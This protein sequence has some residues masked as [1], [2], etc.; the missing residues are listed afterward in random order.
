MDMT[1]RLISLFQTTA[2]RAEWVGFLDAVKAA[3]FKPAQD[4]WPNP[5]GDA[6]GMFKAE[7]AKSE[8][9]QKLKKKFGISGFGFEEQ[10][11]GTYIKESAYVIGE[12]VKVWMGGGKK[13]LGEVKKVAFGDGFY[14]VEVAGQIVSRSLH[15]LEPFNENK[16]KIVK[17][18]KKN[19]SLDEAV[20]SALTKSL[21]EGLDPVGK[22][23]SDINNDGEIDDTDDYLAHRRT[24]IGRE[25][26]NMSVDEMV[27]EAM[28]MVEVEDEFN[29]TEDGAP[30]FGMEDEEVS[31]VSSGRTTMI[32]ETEDEFETYLT[33]SDEQ[34]I[35]A[36]YSNCC[37]APVYG[38]SDICSAC[39]E[40]CVVEDSKEEERNARMVGKPIEEDHLTDRDSKIE[41]II[42]NSE[43]LP[44]AEEA[45]KNMISDSHAYAAEWLSAMGD[46]EIDSLY[47][48]I[49]AIQTES[50]ID[51]KI[52]SSIDCEVGKA[53]DMEEGIDPEPIKEIKS[54]KRF[55]ILKE[56][57]TIVK[58]IAESK[59]YK[60]INIIGELVESKR[61]G[62]MNIL[63]EKNGRKATIVYNDNI[64][65][66]PW[67]W[68][69]AH[70]NYMQEA[71]DSI[72]ITPKQILEEGYAIEEAELEDKKKVVSQLL[73]QR[74]Y[75]DKTTKLSEA[76]T[77]R[78]AERSQEILKKFL[79]DDLLNR[80]FNR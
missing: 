72:Y 69:G 49:E 76:E 20:E 61:E 43:S 29:F 56:E 57:A 17:V 59:G 25:K 11:A 50:S 30:D 52:E 58:E 77:K 10:E 60:V 34:P 48:A 5:G 64:S 68:N 65:I 53:S 78:R 35:L 40:H 13:A 3:G 75:A 51:Y 6:S 12:K 32:G 47:H 21:E 66:K 70:F 1:N 55:P 42:H 16:D 9:I 8:K 15:E 18:T 41:F 36:G 24:I 22:E 38:E 79:D 44:D 37:D 31:E 62:I 27:A 54:T 80:E 26:E 2:D 74:K 19:L 7:V 4:F 39:K 33:G 63:V 67:S 28:D 45:L 14:F 23:D 71:L 46:E 73:E